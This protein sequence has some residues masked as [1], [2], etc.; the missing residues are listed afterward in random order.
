MSKAIKN[1]IKSLKEMVGVI[2]LKNSNGLSLHNVPEPLLK[3]CECGAKSNQLGVHL[4]HFLLLECQDDRCSN[5]WFVCLNC[6]A[7]RAR[8]TTLKQVRKH[9]ANEKKKEKE[10]I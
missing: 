6:P 2:S 9:V 4:Q 7:Q 8:M 10:E 1:E 3:H 5:E